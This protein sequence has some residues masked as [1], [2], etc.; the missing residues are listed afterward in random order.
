[1]RENFLYFIVALLLV[2]NNAG[3]QDEPEPTCGLRGI[4]SSLE[5]PY[6]LPL[7]SDYPLTR[8]MIWQVSFTGDVNFTSGLPH[9]HYNYIEA[10]RTTSYYRLYSNGLTRYFPR[11]F[12]TREIFRGINIHCLSGTVA[13]YYVIIPLQDMTEPTF[14]EELY[15]MHITTNWGKTRPISEGQFIIVNDNDYELGKDELG[16]HLIFETPNYEGLLRIEPVR[17]WVKPDPEK[18][19]YR[20]DLYLENDLPPGTIQVPLSASDDFNSGSTVIEIVVT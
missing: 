1:M 3:A 7:T 16:K 6:R 10:T 12:N 14:T 9:P 4:T 5:N 18:F 20:L 2:A 13:K 19:Y 8:E 15:T 11:T 17:L